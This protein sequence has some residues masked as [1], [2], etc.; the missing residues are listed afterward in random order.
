MNE[1]SMLKLD[2]KSQYNTEKKTKTE[3]FNFLNTFAKQGQIVFCGDSIVEIWPLGEMFSDL[4]EKTGLKIYN[5][6]ISGDTSNRMAQ[7][8]DENVCTLNPKAVYLLIGTNDIGERYPEE[9]ICHNLKKMIMS[10]RNH[11]PECEIFVQSL[12][13]VNKQI[14]R[15]MVG[16]RKNSELKDLNEQYKVICKE[17]NCTYVDVY[18]AVL[19][20]NGNFKNEYTYDGLH[21]SAPGYAVISEIAQN[22]ISAEL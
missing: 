11:C 15:Y 3:N 4:K 20:H 21:P 6:G 18:N 10:V 7:R 12:L 9:Y 17:N 5:R 19:D 8:L 22:I 16:K 1:K 2:R 14:N 13:P